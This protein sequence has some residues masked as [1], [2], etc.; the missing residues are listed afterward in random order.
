MCAVQNQHKRKS[1]L[2]RAFNSEKEEFMLLQA[3]G[4]QK[5]MKEIDGE[6][7]ICKN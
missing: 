1:L 7:K 3:E 6:K 5:I 4:E 2:K